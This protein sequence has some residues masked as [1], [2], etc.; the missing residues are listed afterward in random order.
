M[1]TKTKNLSCPQQL[2]RL[3]L[4]LSFISSNCWRAQWELLIFIILIYS[5]PKEYN[6]AKEENWQSQYYAFW[7]EVTA[8]ILLGGGSSICF[9]H[10]WSWS[11]FRQQRRGFVQGQTNGSSLSPPVVMRHTVLDVWV[12]EASESTSFF[13]PSLSAP[14][15]DS[16]QTIICSNLLADARPPSWGLSHQPYL[17]TTSMIYLNTTKVPAR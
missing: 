14:C 9:W 1:K 8:A 16:I 4:L 10:L 7:K 12:R 15:P 17:L 3:P 5:E 13:S 2:L 11:P 6:T